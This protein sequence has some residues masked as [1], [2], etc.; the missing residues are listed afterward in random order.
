MDT[1]LRHANA[2]QAGAQT[3]PQPLTPNPLASRANLNLSRDLIP[4]NAQ[5]IHESQSAKAA[6][7]SANAVTDTRSDTEP[8]TLDPGSMAFL[9]AWLGG[10]GPQVGGQSLRQQQQSYLE[11]YRQRCPNGVPGITNYTTATTNYLT[12]TA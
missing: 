5:D 6:V 12:R 7:S 3:D 8:S 11:S 4:R 10:G 1:A 2:Q 9:L